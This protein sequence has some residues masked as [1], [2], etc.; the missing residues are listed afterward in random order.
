MTKVKHSPKIVL[1]LNNFF[2]EISQNPNQAQKQYLEDKTGL[3]QKQLN[4]W[5]K[6]KRIE[7]KQ[8]RIQTKNAL[9]VL[10]N[11]IS[12]LFVAS[13]QSEAA[14]VIDKLVS[15]I[16]SSQKTFP[17]VKINRKNA[18]EMFQDDDKSLEKALELCDELI[19][20][21]DDFQEEEA[22]LL[23]SDEEGPEFCAPLFFQNALEFIVKQRKN[24]DETYELL[25]KINCEK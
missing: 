23:L 9:L 12:S 6:K 15:Q 10:Q 8:D 18:N 25:W 13:K 22:F 5:F 16:S 11:N 1:F 19:E 24:T 21:N 3:T 7:L 17:N 20:D 2:N 4:N 14:F